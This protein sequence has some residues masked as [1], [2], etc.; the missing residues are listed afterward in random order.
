MPQALRSVNLP[1]SLRLTSWTVRAIMANVMTFVRL[2]LRWSES[3]RQSPSPFRKGRVTTPYGLEIDKASP[4][5]LWY[6]LR[7][8]M[9][10]Q[11][12][13][14]HWKAD[15]Q[16]P[17]ENELCKLLG[18]SRSTVRSAVQSLVR[19]G[20]VVRSAG[21]G[22][23]VASRPS[24]QIRVPPLGFHRAMTSRGFGVRSEILEV[25]IAPATKD[26]VQDLNLREAEEI[27]HIRRLRYINDRPVV[28][29]RNYLIYSMCRGLEEED[30][31]A[32]SLWERLEHRLGRRIAGG[33]HT[34]YAIL[35][36][37]EEQRLLQLPADVPLLMS[38]G[39]NY[40]EDGSPFERAEVKIPGDYGFVVARHVAPSRPLDSEASLGSSHP[41]PA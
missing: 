39:T 24:T 33:I 18:I 21:K 28:L 22:S 20:L 12:A 35:P 1:T 13:T 8:A 30:L 26:L 37:D 16:L 9:L 25:S 17:T 19:D 31:S 27:L 15:H 6:Q 29:A 38:A 32:G 4:V 36:T 11:I 5:Q 40:L 3:D 2:P 14:G 10:S 34:F 41:V 23:F 7:M